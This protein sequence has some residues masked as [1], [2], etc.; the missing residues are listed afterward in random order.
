MF[1]ILN[2]KTGE[3]INQ[4]DAQGQ[5]IRVELPTREAA[6]ARLAAYRGTPTSFPHWEVREI[7]PFSPAEPG[8][9]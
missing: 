1:G 3:W 2:T 9:E 7:P 6:E 4:G 5:I 8:G